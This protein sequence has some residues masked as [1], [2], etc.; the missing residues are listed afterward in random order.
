MIDFDPIDEET[1][2]EEYP[3]YIG[4]TWDGELSMSKGFESLKNFSWNNYSEIVDEIGG[5]REILYEYQNIKN[6]VK[7]EAYRDIG[8][9]LDD[10]ITTE[11]H[12]DDGASY[13]GMASGS[14]YIF[15][16]KEGYAM[17]HAIDEINIVTIALQKD[18]EL[19]LNEK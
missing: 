7:F 10:L 14:G 4:M 8:F 5:I 9:L 19:C 16:I 3:G 11:V 1:G 2:I 18:L 17:A 15:F 13:G 6:Y 12:R